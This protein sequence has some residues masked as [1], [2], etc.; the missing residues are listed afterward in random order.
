[1]TLADDEGALDVRD[2][3]LADAHA[4][5]AIAIHTGFL[6]ESSIEIAC[7]NCDKAWIVS[8]CAHLSMAPFVDCEL[9]D[10]ELDALPDWSEER[11]LR[12]DVPVELAPRTLRQAAPLHE[13]LGSGAT[14]WTPAALEGIGVRRLGEDRAPGAIVRALEDKPDWRQEIAC[15]FLEAHYPMRLGA[16]VLCPSCGA[17]NDVDAPYEREFAWPEVSASSRFVSLDAFDAE[18][19]RIADAR[20]DSAEGIVFIVDGGVPACDDGG[21]PLLGSY[22]PPRTGDFAMPEAPAEITVYYR[23]FAS[24]WRDGPFDWR[25]ELDETIAHELEHHQAFLRGFDETDEDERD[26]IRDEAAR[27]LGRRAL[28][29][30]GVRGTALDLVEFLRRTWPLWLTLLVLTAWLTCEPG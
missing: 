22:V 15:M 29:R 24:V 4:L 2:L 11:S 20:I 17:R 3:A 21:E 5:R 28:V 6:A 23:T 8:P 27:I 13:A 16:V 10:E 12:D 25:A 9:D 19:R 26:E 30:E 14:P 7:R 18:A 1:M